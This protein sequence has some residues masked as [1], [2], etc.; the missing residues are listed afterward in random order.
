MDYV[1]EVK[2]QGEFDMSRNLKRL[3]LGM[4]DTCLIAMSFVVSYIWLLRIVNQNI[5][6]YFPTYLI[7]VGLYVLFGVLFKVFSRINRYV[8]ITTVLAIGYAMVASFLVHWLV[9][10]RWLYDIDIRLR[11]L[12]LSYLF[13]VLLICISRFVWALFAQVINHEKKSILHLKRT[14]LVGAGEAANVFFK[15]LEMDDAKFEIIGIVD[16]NV[17]KRGTYLHNIRVLGNIDDIA[18]VVRDRHIE[19]VIIAIPSLSAGRI[20]EIVRICNAIGVTVNRMPHAQDILI[21][22]FELNRLREVS[23]AD[24]LGREVVKLDVAGLKTELLNKV[25]LV[26]GAGGSIG[27]EICRQVVRFRPSKLLLVGQGENSIYHI[28]RELEAS[29]GHRTQIIPIIAD[30]KDREKIFKLMSDYRPDTVYHAAAHKHVPLMEVNPM[31]AVKN[32]IFGTKNVAEASK[33]ANVS[34]FVMV[35]TDKAVNPTNVM[36]AS[37]RIAEMIVTGLSEQGQKADEAGTKLSA[38]R[39]GNVLGSRGSVIPL[40]QE[41]IAKG[42]PITLTDRRM[43][44]Y[45]MTIPEASRLVIQSGMLSRGGEVFILDMGEPVKIYDLAKKMITLSG[46]SEKDI[47][48]VETGIR[49]GEKLF[50]ELLLTGEEV[51]QNIFEKIFVGQVAS[52]PIDD[53]VSFVESLEDSDDLARKLVAFA[54]Q[55][56]LTKKKDFLTQVLELKS[57]SESS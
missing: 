42:G 49:P 14:L 11:F 51:K 46:L 34:K 47:Q 30:V 43:T 31:E 50:E 6:V 5:F 24:L 55:K 17:N 13:S 22:G 57:N 52:L 35:S 53:V 21:N 28:H 54:N 3:I 26:T 36:G 38:V 15:S 29:Y 32:N 4:A 12:S 10:N 19:H 56:C 23:V 7:T 2:G 25:I 44:R 40:F 37:K 9:V 20:E 48:I 33:A 8:D 1:I 16:D 39:F 45:F 18:T 41:Q 27:S